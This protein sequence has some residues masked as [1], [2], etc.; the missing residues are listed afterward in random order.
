MDERISSRTLHFGHFKAACKKEKVISLHYQLAEIP[1][2]SGYSP[3]RWKNATN[4]MI[5]KKEGLYDVDRLRTIVLYEADFNHNNKY[6]GKSMMEHTM[7]SNLLVKEQYSIPGKKAI[8]HVINRRLIFDITCYQKTSLA[9]TACDLKSC[10][11]RIANIPAY[12]A[13]TSYGYKPTP[14]FS[15]FTCI[16]D[17]KWT[18]RTIFGDSTK[19][20]GGFHP[21]YTAKPQGVGQGNGSGP[22]VWTTV[23]SKMF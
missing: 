7:R 19:V 21:S 8:G 17:M 6:L 2:Q 5:L 11:N 9:L 15:M 10:Y 22:L 23:S 16:Q 3:K 13:M 20:F 18:T 12:L 1:F 4:V 14:I